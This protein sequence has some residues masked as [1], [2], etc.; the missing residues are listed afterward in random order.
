MHTKLNNIDKFIFNGLKKSLVEYT[1]FICQYIEHLIINLSLTLKE[2]TA[3]TTK[4]LNNK[5][6]SLREINY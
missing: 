3:T 5:D 2:I 4:K 6:E 1:F